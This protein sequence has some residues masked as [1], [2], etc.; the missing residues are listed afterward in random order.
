MDTL[1]TDL[2]IRRTEGHSVTIRV[3]PAFDYAGVEIGISAKD[4]AEITTVAGGM[5]I[6]LSPAE[7]QF[8]ADA[9]TNSLARSQETK[10]L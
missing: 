6:F 3:Y 2:T 7:V 9:L 10:R 8:L 1:Y 4:G 5:P